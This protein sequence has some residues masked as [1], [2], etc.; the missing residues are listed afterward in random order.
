MFGPTIEL[1]DCQS[2]YNLLNEGI[3]Y[4]KLCDSN[5]L[6]LIGIIFLVHKERNFH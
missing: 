4:A 3:E 6:Y 2:L 5:Y 1:I